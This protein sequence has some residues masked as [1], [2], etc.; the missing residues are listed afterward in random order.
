MVIQTG[1]L[2]LA[3]S[4]GMWTALSS[5]HPPL[6]QRSF[7]FYNGKK[8]ETFPKWKDGTPIGQINDFFSAVIDRFDRRNV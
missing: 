5:S 4:S 3:G 2:A 1:T 7:Q 6:E 8:G